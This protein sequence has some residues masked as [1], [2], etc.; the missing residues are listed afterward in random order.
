ML[1]EVCLR[2]WSIESI[3]V[4][5]L[6]ICVQEIM[7]F[8]GSKHSGLSAS[9]GGWLLVKDPKFALGVQAYIYNTTI[10]VPVDTQLRL[11][12]HAKHILSWYTYDTR[13]KNVNNFLF[14]T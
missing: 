2:I 3:P 14:L 5:L 10:G 9:R 6:L 4:S 1:N 12:A 13:C 11:L 7:V 8:S